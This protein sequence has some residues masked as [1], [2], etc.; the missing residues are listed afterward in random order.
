MMNYPTDAEIARGIIIT[1]IV[2]GYIF[3]YAYGT[4]ILKRK[5]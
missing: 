2:I 4:D 3:W 5:K 1:V